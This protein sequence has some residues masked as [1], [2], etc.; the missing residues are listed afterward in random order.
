LRRSRTD[1]ATPLRRRR[2]SPESAR[3]VAPAAVVSAMRAS[4]L[5]EAT[6]TAPAVAGRVPPDGAGKRG[7]RT[8]V[9]DGLAA[10]A[11]VARPGRRR[12]LHAVD[13]ARGRLWL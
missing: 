11:A 1:P 3:Y 10:V 13:R 8:R 2:Q 4:G 6:G 5:C 7:R 12:I 9:G